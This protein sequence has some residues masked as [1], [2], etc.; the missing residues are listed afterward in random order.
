MS[1]SKVEVVRK[2]DFFEPLDNKIV[3]QIAQQCFE[4]EFAA[5]DYIIRQ[6]EPGLGL[7][8]ITQG[9]VKVEIETNG[10]TVPVA[11]LQS[12]AFLGELSI[13]D[14]QARSANVVCLESTQCLLLTRDSFSKLMNKHPEILVQMVKTL[15]RRIRDTNTAVTQPARLEPASPPA[16]TVAASPQ[17]KEETSPLALPIEIFKTYSAVKGKVRDLV[18]D[19]FAPLY[20][21]KAIT[22]FSMAVIGCPVRVE[23]ENSRFRVLQTSVDDVKILLFP[24]GRNQTLR[25]EAFGSGYVSATVFRPACG[26]SRISTFRLEARITDN[27]RWRLHVP[28]ARKIWMEVPRVETIDSRNPR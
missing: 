2:L 24:A 27:E 20:A 15:A 6:G 16:D 14:E 25:L 13:V 22:R 12:G 5:G 26:P 23:A 17:A 8:F 1:L 18:V 21:M 10:R 9:T 4:R 11:Q 3:K 19:V 7:Y 28:S